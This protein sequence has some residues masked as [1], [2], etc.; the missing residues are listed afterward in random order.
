MEVM[1]LDR[2]WERWECLKSENIEL[3]KTVVSCEMLLE[4]CQHIVKMIQLRERLNDVGSERW[5]EEG[6]WK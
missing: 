5:L 4:E 6:G 1:D 2:H 3:H